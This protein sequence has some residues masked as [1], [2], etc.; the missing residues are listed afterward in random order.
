M[1]SN[2]LN[3]VAI[4]SD[5][6]AK[7]EK[8]DKA[9]RHMDED[10]WKNPYYGFPEMVRFAFNPNKSARE[11]LKE[12]RRNGYTYALSAL[13]KPKSVNKDSEGKYQEFD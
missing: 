4:F 11:K 9:K 10:E 2:T 8:W 1:L 5:I 3:V 6:V 12:L 7:K 13:L